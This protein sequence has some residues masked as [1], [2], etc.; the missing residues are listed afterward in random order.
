MNWMKVM[1]VTCFLFL[2]FCFPSVGAFCAEL[3]PIQVELV[4][5]QPSFTGGREY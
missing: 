5:S 3:Q 4:S 2:A 1:H